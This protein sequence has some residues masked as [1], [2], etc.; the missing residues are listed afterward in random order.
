MKK[1]YMTDELQHQLQKKKIKILF[2]DLNS[3]KV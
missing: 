3:S 2:L 1:N